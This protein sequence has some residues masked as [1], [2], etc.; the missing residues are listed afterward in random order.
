MP[1]IVWQSNEELTM[2]KCQKEPARK[3]PGCLVEECAMQKDGCCIALTD[4]NFGSR[5]CPFFKTEEQV[6]KEEY[7]N[8]LSNIRQGNQEDDLC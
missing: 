4:N 3:L 6:A 2:K 5:K 7:E 8:R 1:C